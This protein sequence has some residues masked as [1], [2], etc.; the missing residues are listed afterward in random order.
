MCKIATTNHRCGLCNRLVSSSTEYRLC[1]DVHRRNANVSKNRSRK[2]KDVELGHGDCGKILNT[3]KTLRETKCPVACE[4]DD[5]PDDDMIE[6]MRDVDPGV[7]F[8]HL[9][10]ENGQ[11]DHQLRDKNYADRLRTNPHDRGR[12]HGHDL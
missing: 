3:G 11:V 2:G 12:E 4:V 8:E 10:S 5:L 9:V 6:E 1:E 7:E